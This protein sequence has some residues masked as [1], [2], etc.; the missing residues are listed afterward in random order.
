MRR[1]HKDLVSSGRSLEDA[2]A[3][4]D[5]LGPLFAPAV[6]RVKGKKH[7]PLPQPLT[8]Q[9]GAGVGHRQLGTAG[10]NW[11]AVVLA[12]AGSRGWPHLCVCVVNDTMFV[13]LGIKDFHNLLVTFPV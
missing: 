9:V 5:L 3:I 10:H 13:F 7:I 12:P 11:M 6:L 8:R 1:R 4:Y 2:G